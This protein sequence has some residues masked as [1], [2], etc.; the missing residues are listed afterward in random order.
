MEA[1]KVTFAYTPNKNIFEDLSFSVN[2]G[3]IFCILG[4]NGTGKSTLLRCVG[5]LYK[6][7]KGKVLV[8]GKDIALFSPANLA[9]KI[10][11]IAQTHTPTFPYKVLDVVLMGR[12]PH[13]NLLATPS[14]KDYA[15]AEKA[16][17]TL[18]IDHL[19]DKPYTKLSGGEMQLV[20]FA[21]VL[22]QAPEILLLDEPTSHLDIANQVRTIELIRKLAKEKLCIV[23]TSHFPDHAFYI[24]DKVALMKN[25]TFIA[26]GNVDEVMTENNLKETYGVDIKIIYLGGEI[27]RKIAVPLIKKSSAL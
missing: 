7:C 8:G 1:D 3:E 14:Q 27:S 18:E 25:K 6:M 12:T 15:L 17:H 13:L 11:F 26:I 16:I 21:R 5:G 20:L 19:R 24:S 2:S 4:P 22:A 9:K 23:M 10:G